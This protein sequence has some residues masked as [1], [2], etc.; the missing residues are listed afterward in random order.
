MNHA[1]SERLHEAIDSAL[2]AMSDADVVAYLAKRDTDLMLELRDRA[3]E[4]LLSAAMECAEDAR[5]ESALMEREA[6]W[7]GSW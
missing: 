2:D 1:Q 4:S 5:A 7:E 6:F 3:R